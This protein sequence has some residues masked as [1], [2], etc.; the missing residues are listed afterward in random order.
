MDFVE[1]AGTRGYEVVFFEPLMRAGVD[2]NDIKQFGDSLRGLGFKFSFINMFHLTYFV[3][4]QIK[5]NYYPLSL[6]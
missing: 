1:R 4:I 3:K 2:E 6:S 5:Q